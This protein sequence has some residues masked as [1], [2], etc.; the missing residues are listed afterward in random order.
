MRR[1]RGLLEALEGGLAEVR[2]HKLR[3]VLQTLGVILGVGSLV[4]VQALADAGRRQSLRFFAEVGGLTKIG[5]VNRPP[6]EGT[7]T[8]KELRSK[9]LTLDDALALRAEVR[10]AR[11]VDPMSWSWQ[12]VRTPD[13][14]EH[15]DVTGVTP[16]YAA[17]YKFWPERG[18]FITEDD[19]ARAAPVAV[20]GDT[21]AKLLFGNA[22]PLGRTVQIGESGF[23]V[24]G[25]MRRK[26]FFFEGRDDNALEWMNRMTIVPLSAVHARFNGD[27]DRR[28]GFVNVVV[29]KVADIP[30]ASE[31]IRG[32]LQ[33]RHGVVDFRVWN[34]SDRMAEQEERMK[35]FDITFLVAGL[36]SLIVGGVV[37]MNIMLASFQ[38]R[39][40]EV[41]VRKALGARPLDI[42]VQ[43]LVETVLVTVLG[44]GAGLLAG[45]ALAQGITGLLKMPAE[46]T[47]R[48]GVVAVG[49]AVAVGF[50]FGLYPAV[51]AARLV[52]VEALRYE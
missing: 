21:A 12:L 42:A 50:V 24:V 20:L 37:I 17:V 38:E 45:I 47:L 11:F 16:D 4:A 34:R 30:K 31:A 52:P 40:R 19:L 41:G 36:V 46:I 18:R 10:E 43:F 32:L 29:G 28:I 23:V 8:A 27:T 5:V 51:R 49:A 7:A 14:Q 44:S 3:T 9:G 33:R 39:V 2:S 15:R 6:Q 25:V 13:Y 35:V 22:N 1:A 26:E 48:M